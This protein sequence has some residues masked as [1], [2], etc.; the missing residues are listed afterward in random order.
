MTGLFTFA[1]GYG[2]LMGL[3]KLNEDRLVFPVMPWPRALELPDPSLGLYPVRIETTTA[4]GV[5]LVGWR[6]QSG[7]APR[8]PWLLM[9]HGN[10]GDVSSSGRPEHYRALLR[11]GL[12][13]LAFDYRGYGES[14][15]RP[16]EAGVYRDADAAYAYLRDTLGVPPERIVIFGHSLGSAVAVDLAS[17]VP[18]RA[19]VVE[20]ALTS[21]P[22]VGQRTYFFL[23][24]RLLARNRFASAEKIGRVTIPKLF[25]HARWDEVIPFD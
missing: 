18:A 10:G 21:V 12:N 11:L 7:R 15:G 24:V 6:M 23:P 5:R 9:F 16:S 22:D 4:D 14:E 2:T 19:L 13:L 1:F 20:G 3:L 25:L 8:R 17:R